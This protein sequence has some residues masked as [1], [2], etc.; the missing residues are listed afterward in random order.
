MPRIRLSGKCSVL[1]SRRFWSRLALLLLVCLACFL[2][3]VAQVL[4]KSVQ[5]M[6]S[7]LEK[8]LKTSWRM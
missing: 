3:A 1:I 4:R 2:V 7:G 8:A 5:L 6:R